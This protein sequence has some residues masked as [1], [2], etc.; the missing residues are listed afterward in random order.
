MNRKKFVS[1]LLISIILSLSLTSCSN[2]EDKIAEYSRV[3]ESDKR[4]ET[5]WSRLSEA[6]YES[7]DINAAIHTLEKCIGV[8]RQ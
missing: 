1:A 3:V 2:A 5:A 6:Y 8:Y 4:S 7:G